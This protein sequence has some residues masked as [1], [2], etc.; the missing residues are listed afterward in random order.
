METVQNRKQGV[1][2]CVAILVSAIFFVGWFGFLYRNFGFHPASVLSLICALPLAAAVRLCSRWPAV[3][4]REL[5]FLAILFCAVGGGSIFVV[6]AWYTDGLYERY[7][8]DLRWAEFERRLRRDPSFCDVQV[9]LSEL[10][11]IHWASGEFDSD[12]DLARLY[13]LATDCGIKKRRLDR[14]FVHS[15]TLTVRRQPGK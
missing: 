2:L 13:S 1:A 10:K 8:E 6:R 12:A 5:A 7:A 14:P 11:N 3:R 4:G 9:H 15:V